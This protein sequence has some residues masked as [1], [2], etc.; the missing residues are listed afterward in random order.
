MFKWLHAPIF[1]QEG[2]YEKFKNFSNEPFKLFI[3]KS[4]RVL[5]SKLDLTKRN[6]YQTFITI[7]PL[8][9]I[10]IYIQFELNLLQSS[11]YCEI[12]NKIFKYDFPQKSNITSYADR[13]NH[14]F[15]TNIA[16]TTWLFSKG[17]FQKNTWHYT[18]NITGVVFMVRCILYIP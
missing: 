11:L 17:Y 10:Y 5:P 7:S 16:W 14:I 8:T 2:F 3:I 4:W 1:L 12:W 15:W 6:M 18:S 9:Y 13:P